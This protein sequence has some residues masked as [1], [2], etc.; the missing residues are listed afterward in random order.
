MPVGQ[1]TL[2][3]ENGGRFG[4]G[5][6]G[7]YTAIP[8][9]GNDPGKSVED[10]RKED[11]D[12]LFGGASRPS[13]VFVTRIRTDIAH[14]ALSEDLLLRAPADQSLFSNVRQV[15]RELNEPLCPVYVGCTQSGVAPRSEAFRRS[16]ESC[17]T[18]GALPQEGFAAAALG[19]V[20]LAVVRAGRR[21]RKS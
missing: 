9:S 19:F 11:L 10:V 16:T 6:S 17:S 14:A 18:T 3:L 21:R 7:D 5:G 2:P 8:P 4:N 1:I 12:V 15:T 13:D 20:G